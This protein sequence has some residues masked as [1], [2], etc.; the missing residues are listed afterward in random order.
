MSMEET[1]RPEGAEAAYASVP[2]SAEA[3]PEAAAILRDAGWSA[4]PEWNVYTRGTLV[5]G[6][7]SGSFHVKD[8]ARIQPGHPL[9]SE[10][11][12][13]TA[14]E[15]A[16]WLVARFANP[17][18]TSV[19]LEPISLEE[20]SE[21]VESLGD[22]SNGETGEASGGDGDAQAD[23]LQHTGAEGGPIGVD[24]VDPASDGPDLTAAGDVGGLASSDPLDADFT[25]E[26]LG[27]LE[28][29]D[30]ELPTLEA[31][32]PEDFAPDEIKPQEDQSGAFIFGDNL[33]QLRTAAIGLVVQ[34]A[35]NRQPAG[36]DYARL[37]E[38][39]NFVMGVS[40]QRWP[41]DPAKRE[42]LDTLEA[43]E[44]RRRAI[45]ADRDARVEWIM[46]ANREDL[47]AYDPEAGWP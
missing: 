2:E 22:E 5:M 33:H 13:D 26:D 15:A 35:L 39:R 47:A 38:L 46:E 24:M 6:G 17:L 11:T 42:E 18:T 44:R 45:D 21:A 20:G 32:L 30:I 14:E 40:E 34:A 43:T 9:Y 4:H 16:T 28:A 31:P 36:I 23:P 41:D 37:S 27:G 3:Y 12:P 7:F 25:V 1:A 10:D 29:E 8:W 19:T